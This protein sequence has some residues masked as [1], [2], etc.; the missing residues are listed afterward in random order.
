MTVRNLDALFHGSRLVILGTAETPA[1]Q[2]LL[3]NLENSAPPGQRTQITT[4]PGAADLPSAEVA[5]LMRADWADAT[6]IAALGR[7]G[8]KALLWA[9][10]TPPGLEI[11]QAAKPH[12]MRLLGSR[13][14][15][16]I[17]PARHLNLSSLPLTPRPGA[18]A[19]IAQS[20]SVAA[21]ALDWAVGRSIGFS[22]L[23]VTG[24]EADV[25][26]ADLLDYAALDPQTRAVVLQIG[27]I[28]HARKFMSAARAAARLK[29]VLVL[30]T[31][32]ASDAGTGGPDPARSAAFQ[33][34]GMV[35]CETLGG[36][37]DGLAA[38]ELLP[39]VSGDRISVVG[40][41][42]GVC[43][44]ATDAVL[45]Q[46]MHPAVLSAHTRQQIAE[47]VPQVRFVGNAVDLGNAAASDVLA[48]LRSV[49]ADADVSAALLIHS[50][51]AGQP[52]QVLADAIASAGLGERLLTVWLGLH[53]AQPARSSSA[54]A[55]LATFA[56][57]D[58]AVRA[59][60]Y[61]AQYRYTR[62]MLGQT[63]PPDALLS[64]D[65]AAIAKSLHG[66]CTQG[67][68]QLSAKEGSRLLAKYG[69]AG[70]AKPSRAMLKFRINAARHAELGMVLN[71]R[72]EPAS[73][74]L[75]PAYGLP[76]LDELLAQRML[77]EAGGLVESAAAANAMTAALIR[78]GQLVIDQPLI[79]RLD[80]VMAWTRD[81][82][83]AALPGCI[84]E[85]ADQDLPERER[86]A[87]A[88]YPETLEHGTKSRSG[89]RYQVRAVRP[90]DE[91]AVLRLLARLDP[92]EIRLRF[93]MYIRH[94]SHDMAARVTQVDYDREL[95]L[96]A[97]AVA[98][99]GEIAAM[100]TLVA[101][102]DG[103]E[104][105]YAVLVHHDHAR[106]GLGRHL[107]ERLLQIARDRGISKVHGDV[108]ADNV[109][110]LGLVH[111]LG[112][113]VSAI[114][115]DPSSRRVEISTGEYAASTQA[116]AV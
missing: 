87:L 27:K 33:R 104:A 5:V 53:S 75:A 13:S 51:M 19:L 54:A 38:L 109:P 17:H 106:Q 41:G 25:D 15:G 74:K 101:D 66:F 64:V 112:F 30:Q 34:A 2:Q 55:R 61:R 18:V 36:L 113:S 29:P 49:L 10:D 83:L 21:A 88:P 115:D 26:V 73:P 16:V 105:E 7:R 57:A 12:M 39:S 91:P 102:P 50:P 111:S 32:H 62:E 56:S 48:A 52:H 11:L 80:V 31:R 69:L 116:G 47:Q 71:V 77:D 20:P 1:Q 43:A 60:R 92:E 3:R 14:A 81:E 103:R 114:A 24:A 59:L 90:A 45:R 6:C 86:I 107:L 97:S 85:I 72:T 79:R 8:C 84:V 82:R 58:E 63:P 96:V 100:A 42:L 40:N 95:T 108:L 94:F 4:K 37:F 89:Q 78:I 65:S 23:A 22:W 46:G 110:M 99:P 44:L 9:A 93:F 98:E 70:G 68:A 76:P 28:S 35:E 67:L